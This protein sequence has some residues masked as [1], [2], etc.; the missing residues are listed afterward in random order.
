MNI[1]LDNNATTK[2]DSRVTEIMTQYVESIYGNASSI[3]RIGI[4]AS[5]GIENARNII[6]SK[7]NA[8]PEE[9]Y[10]TSGGTESNN[11]ALKGVYNANKD[12]GNHIIVSS[13]EHPSILET[14]KW[15]AKNNAKITYLPVDKIG[16]VKI[17]DVRKAISK[18]T[19]LVSVMHCNNEVGTIEPIEEIG[20][21]CRKNNLIFHSDA[22]QSFTKIKIDVIKQNINLLSLNAHKIHG[23]K[24][25]GALFI[26]KGTPI[27]PFMHGGGHENGQRAGTY[28]S[29]A[30]VGFGKA[31]EIAKEQENT[32]I[33]NMRDYF[34]SEINKR[35]SCY[36]LHGTV[37][38]QRICNNI[39]ISFN[40][41]SGK[42]LFTELN[43]RGIYIST[44]SACSSNNLEPSYVLTAMGICEKV[45][46]E[47]IR[48]SLS[49]WTTLEEIDTTINNVCNIVNSIRK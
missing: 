3:H 37:G 26:K 28:N 34:I 20:K 4:K 2:T 29:P 36:T 30:I 33:K 15:L 19:I 22:C 42:S 21:L 44:G 46:H 38:N 35:L 8:F 49:K 41:I 47:A 9:I 43:K 31:V 14:T 39:N 18:K 12:K 6:A 11:W 17:E 1:Y 45:A 48:I 24:G 5:L 13:I 40:N 25:I 10:F 32:N 27:E 7:I 16:F 23:P